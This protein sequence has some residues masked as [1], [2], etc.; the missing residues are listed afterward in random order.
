LVNI[1]IAYCELSG[2]LYVAMGNQEKAQEYLIDAM[3]SIREL[4]EGRKK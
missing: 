1:K 2:E 3:E 4:E